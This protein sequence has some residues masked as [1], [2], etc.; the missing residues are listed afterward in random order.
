MDTT[1]PKSASPSHAANKSADGWSQVA[2]KKPR[3]EAKEDPYGNGNF[4]V[5]PS[6]K[7]GG[8]R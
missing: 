2:Q 8:K 6:K 4:K 1:I 7:K 3:E 5:V